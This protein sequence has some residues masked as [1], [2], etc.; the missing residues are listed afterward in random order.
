[1]YRKGG[2]YGPQWFAYDEVSRES[3]W[4]PIVGAFTRYGDVLPLLRAPDDMYVI[5]APGDETTLT[6]DEGSVPV[7]RPGWRRDFLLYTDAWLKDS[8]R[9][10]ATGGTVA[11]LPFHGMA[12]YPYGADEAYP[13]DAAHEHYLDAYNT[14]RV[15]RSYRR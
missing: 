13:G 14:R 11:P 15:E 8:D 5:M 3:P 4:E 7:L 1:M 9:N 12:R 6:F 10:T 2:R